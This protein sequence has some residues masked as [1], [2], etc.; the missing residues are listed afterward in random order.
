[1]ETP[2]PSPR[3]T[4]EAAST[5][6]D[7][8]VLD[9]NVV[10]DWLLF[11]DRACTVLSKRLEARQLSWHATEVMRAELASVLPRPQLQ[12]WRFEGEYILTT[13]DERVVLQPACTVSTEKSGLRCRDADDQKF[14]DLACAIGARW[15]LTRDRA[16]LDL[17]KAAGRYGVEVLRPGDWAQRYG[18][19]GDSGKAG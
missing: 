15:L 1:M 11:R 3:S 13:F 8:V 6:T 12:R 9:T 7:V 19:G 10:L 4:T 18:G 16:L 14:I 17:A 2:R 5:G